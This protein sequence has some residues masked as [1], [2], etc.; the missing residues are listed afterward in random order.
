VAMR[1]YAVKFKADPDKWSVVDLFH[2]V[3]YEEN[4]KLL[5]LRRS[6]KCKPKACLRI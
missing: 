6:A 3:V 4:A 5:I 1:I 2:D